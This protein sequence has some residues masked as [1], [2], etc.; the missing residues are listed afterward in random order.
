MPHNGRTLQV[1]M[2]FIGKKYI[3]LLHQHAQATTRGHAKYLG[4][5]IKTSDS[6]HPY[7]SLLPQAGAST[8]GQLS[9]ASTDKQHTPARCPFR[10][11]F[12]STQTASSQPGCPCIQLPCAP[13]N[14]CLPTLF[15]DS[16]FRTTT[17]KVK[18]ASKRPSPA[19]NVAGKPRGVG[20]CG[21]AV[22]RSYSNARFLKTWLQQ[23]DFQ[24]DSPGFQI[25]IILGTNYQRC[26]L[27]LRPWEGDL[28]SAYTL[29]T[30]TTKNT[31][32][33]KR[34]K[35]VKYRMKKFSNVGTIVE[36]NKTKVLE[37]KL[38]AMKRTIVR[39][40]Y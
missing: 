27:G 4:A 31:Q 7:Q 15:W 8:L 35:K 18:Q 3:L 20:A 21:Y 40:S 26:M 12:H 2:F 36:F 32:I 17:V 6:E 9:L 37:E 13:T 29:E 11:D 10:P 28:S 1:Y 23:A 30:Y 25:G 16:V 33:P 24:M 34:A 19:E 38:F 39:Q 22:W 5:C 14:K